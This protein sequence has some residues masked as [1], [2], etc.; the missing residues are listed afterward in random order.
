MRNRNERGIAMI[1]AMLS[2][3]ILSTLGASIIF[4]TQNEI[5][6]ATNYK[7]LTQSRYAAETGLQ[8]TADWIIN[9]Y[10]VP[11]TFTSFNMATSP[12]QSTGGSNIV[13]SAMNGDTWTGWDA[14]YPT[15]SVQTAFNTAFNAQPVTGMGITATYSVK[16]R[17]HS[18]K[19][20]RTIGDVIVPIQVWEVRSRTRCA[21]G[22]ESPSG[23]HRPSNVWLCG[24]RSRSRMRQRQC[25]RQRRHR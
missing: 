18:M 22:A 19:T 3:L 4:M 20:V 9:T 11:T 13:L 17:L 12:T 1:V 23:E 2:L 21:S 15:G 24:L 7:N 25:C 6:T 8:N 10:P 5:W 16:A 14:N